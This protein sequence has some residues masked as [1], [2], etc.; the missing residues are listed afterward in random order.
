MEARIEADIEKAKA[1][2]RLPY[3]DG[4]AD[5]IIEA[6]DRMLKASSQTSKLEAMRSRAAP[7]NYQSKR[8][9]HH[10]RTARLSSGPRRN[11][12]FNQDKVMTNA[13][14]AIHDDV[15]QQ[16][17]T[18]QTTKITTTLIDRRMRE[19]FPH[20]FTG[21]AQ[22]TPRSSKGNVATVVTP[23]GN[24]SGRS[25]RSDFHLHRWP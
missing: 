6:Q 8:L 20:K 1:D 9:L 23:G 11:K 24:E 15:V 17:G 13:A 14:Y 22:D 18:L 7:E 21:R 10:R 3:E 19:E 2:Y 5:R 4:D 12:W 25:K 16:W